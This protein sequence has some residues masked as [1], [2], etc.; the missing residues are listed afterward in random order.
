M[1]SQMR[2][3]PVGSINGVRQIVT[4]LAAATVLAVGLLG[5]ATASADG[6]VNYCS[7]TVNVVCVGQINGAPVNVTIGDVGSGIDLNL[8]RDNLNN[9][10]VSVAHIEDI[11]ILSADLN[12]AVQ[13]VVNSAVT[14]TT[15][16]TTK[17]CTAV[18][19]PPATATQS[20]TI[21][22]GCT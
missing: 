16:T 21:T 6:D 20:S 13:T 8:L 2:F 4:A 5:P 14:T 9:A 17:T 12:A 15:N 22:I 11:N 7:G 10:F 1:M 18:V 19:T 3:A